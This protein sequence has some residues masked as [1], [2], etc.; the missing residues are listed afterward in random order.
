MKLKNLT[1]EDIPSC[2]ALHKKNLKSPGT[3][4]GKPYLIRFYQLLLKN[5]NLHQCLALMEKDQML[6]VIAVTSNYQKTQTILKNVF[7]FWVLLEAF[8]KIVRGQLK[9]GGLLERVAF[10]YQVKDLLIGKS[11]YILA[12]FIDKKF[13]NQGLGRRLVKELIKRSKSKAIYTDTYLTNQTAREFYKS[14]GFKEVK[15]IA[16]SMLLKYDLNK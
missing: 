16:G 7:T 15:Q 2:T 14:L 12:L 6:G 11:V 13:Q 5:R 8:K 10:G 1:F 9:I 4:I 3:D